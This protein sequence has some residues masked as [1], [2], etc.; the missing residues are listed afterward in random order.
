MIQPSI[1]RTATAPEEVCW[2]VVV[3]AVE[4]LLEE[5]PLR[6]GGE[7]GEEPS[8][9]ISLDAIFERIGVC[10]LGEIDGEREG[11]DGEDYDAQRV[12]KVASWC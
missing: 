12:E 7:G 4:G 10:G 1:E 3:I 2:S 6:A 11:D 9:S 8:I 5:E